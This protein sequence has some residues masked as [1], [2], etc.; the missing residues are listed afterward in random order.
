MY[1][2]LVFS[3][4]VTMLI[5]T[6]GLSLSSTKLVTMCACLFSIGILTICNRLDELQAAL[7][8][9]VKPTDSEDNS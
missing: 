4:F 9:K 5:G 7:V 3:S 2:L 1:I 6:S 8:A